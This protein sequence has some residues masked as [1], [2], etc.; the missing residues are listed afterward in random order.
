M[1]AVAGCAP[2]DSWKNR[3]KW[4]AESL[5]LKVEVQRAA[6]DLGSVGRS[7]SDQISDRQ[8][9]RTS[10]LRDHHR[11]SEATSR[12]ALCPLV[13]RR[14]APHRRAKHSDSW[15]SRAVEQC[16]EEL[17]SFLEQVKSVRCP[18]CGAQPGQACIF[19]YMGESR[20][21]LHRD[22]KSAARRLVVPG[23]AMAKTLRGY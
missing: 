7:E 9:D 17:P 18:R 22:R 2:R 6:A 5:L 23:R 16:F 20:D 12:F 14:C 21:G 8:R 15:K 13:Q 4:F 3:M 11:H 1:S 10:T 19:V